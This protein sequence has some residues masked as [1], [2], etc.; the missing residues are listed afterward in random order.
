DALPRAVVLDTLALLGSHPWGT[1]T[2]IAPAAINYRAYDMA[3]PI[4]INC[5]SGGN[6][7]VVNN[8]PLKTIGL[9]LG[10]TINI[11]T[12]SG[13]DHVTIAA[14]SPGTTLNVDGQ[15]SNDQVNVGFNGSVQSI[16]G[17]VTIKNTTNYS[18][19]TI[20]DAND[21]ANRVVTLGVINF[22]KPQ[23]M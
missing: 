21:S 2:G 10:N 9:N 15:A 1:I 6:T 20:D 4:T 5:G 16:Y 23:A 7:V 11:N 13:L 14:T 22:A 17:T 19:L 18:N 12:G 8:T 3:D